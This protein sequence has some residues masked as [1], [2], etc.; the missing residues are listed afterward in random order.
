VTSHTDAQRAIASTKPVSVS[1][2]AVR[3]GPSFTTRNYDID[4]RAQRGGTQS[5][6][7]RHGTDFSNAVQNA[8]EECPFNFYWSQ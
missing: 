4:V 7:K 5:V 3:I 1:R 2:T 6:E 8:A